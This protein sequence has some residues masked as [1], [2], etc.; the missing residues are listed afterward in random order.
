MYINWG[1]ARLVSLDLRDPWGDESVV[2]LWKQTMCTR[3]FPSG[4]RKSPGG[5]LLPQTKRPVYLLI[6]RRSY[7]AG[8]PELDPRGLCA[9]L[10]RPPLWPPLSFPE[11]VEA[12]WMPSLAL[13]CESGHAKSGGLAD[14]C[15]RATNIIINIFS[16][17]KK[18]VFS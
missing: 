10:A 17:T 6:W 16:H 7:H 8:R 2:V 4:A 14:A 5:H 12:A 1:D 13:R 15:L 11:L 3:Q 18:V 9:E